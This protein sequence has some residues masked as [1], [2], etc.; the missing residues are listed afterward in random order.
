MKRIKYFI[1]FFV[2]SITISTWSQ[3]FLLLGRVSGV[4]DVENI[5]VINKTSNKFTTTNSVGAFQ[6][7]AKLNDTIQFTAIKYKR[8][9]VIITMR[10]LYAKELNVTL[11]EL[12]NILDEVVIGKILTGDLDSDIQNS[13]EE[14]QVNFYDLRIPGYTGPPKTQ[15]ERRLFEAG[16]FKPIQLLGLLGGS[17]PINP[18]LNGFSGR[19]K[20]LKERVALERIGNLIISI[21]DRLSVEFF[22]NNLLHEDFRMDFLYFCSE[23]SEFEQRCKNKSDIEVIIFLKEKLIL[24]K[25]NLSETKN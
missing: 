20:M 3:E 21:K 2:F 7:T 13:D 8:K 10:H 5:H 15:S 12:I 6:I 1:F 19:T 9:E 16:E 17:L 11:E 18:I 22:Q 14:R 25:Q 24:Y 4:S 23:D